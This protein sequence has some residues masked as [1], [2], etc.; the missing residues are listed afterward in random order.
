MPFVRNCWYVAAWSR[1]LGRTPLRRQLLGDFVVLYR[2]EA[3]AAV[4]LAD[5]CP[6]R[7]LPLSMGRVVGDALQC[8]Y[9]GM[10]FDAGGQCVH[11]PGQP[12]IP[13]NA[14]V[15]SYPVAEHMGLIW[16]WPGDPAAADPGRIFDLP[17]YHDPDWRAVAGDA[18]PVA[19]SYLSLADNL[20]DPAHVTFV[21][22]STLGT[23]AGQDV[24]VRTEQQGN[25]ILTYRWILDGEP[26][27]LFKRFG[28]FKGRVDRWHYY[29]YHAPQIAVIDFGSAD[30]GRLGPGDDRSQ[31]LQ[32]F[33]C[34]F[35]TPVT[36]TS[37]IDHWL[38]VRNF[39]TLDR[40]ID[41][42][43]NAQFRIA[44]QEDKEILEAIEIEEAR[45]AGAESGGAPRVTLAID[46]GP[47]RMR[48]LVQD[49]I[50]REAAMVRSEGL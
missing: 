50:A 3:G 34:H 25:T 49:M 12:R 22:Q 29:Y 6:H 20:C 24:P 10:T 26:I 19:A 37:S 33:A 27:P 44:F 42:A 23:L 46:A 41:D 32:M 21:H 43:L 11:I 45:Q 31:G 1:E 35:L 4:A 30:T 28:N 2:T 48:K 13:A 17:Q 38:H 14:R 36:A 15:R 39:E 47:Y 16:L 9:H 8:G 7:L 5:V 40:T 18:L